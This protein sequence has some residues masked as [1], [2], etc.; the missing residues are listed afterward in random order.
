MKLTDAQ[1]GTLNTLAEFGPQQAVE[2]HGPRGMD[3]K[4]KVRLEWR[5][6][7]AQ[8]LAKLSSD[9]LVHVARKPLPRPVNAVGKAGHPRT[10]LTISITDAGRESLNAALAA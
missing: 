8:A 3:G 9:G 4:R 10:A 1:F 2:V 5:G 6:V 7:S